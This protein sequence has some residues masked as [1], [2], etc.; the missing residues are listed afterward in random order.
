MKLAEL[1]KLKVAELRSRLKDLGLDNKGLKAELLGRLWSKLE[2]GRGEDEEEE[3]KPQHDRSITPAAQ[4]EDVQAPS[5][6]PKTGPGVTEGCK[7]D[8]TREYTDTSTQTD[9]DTRQQGSECITTLQQ[10]SECITTLQQGSECITTLQQGS[11]CITPLQQGPECVSTLQQASECVSTLQQGSECITTLQ[12]GSEC[13]STLQQGSECI[14]TLQQG[15]ECITTLQQGS[16]CITTLQQASEC[17][18]PLQQGSEC[19]TPLQQAS[20]CITPLQQASECVTPLQQASECVST[21]QQASE[22]ITPLQQA[23]ECITPLQQASECVTP[24]QQGSGCTSECVPVYQAEETD[25]EMQQGGAEDAGEDRRALSSED[26]GRGRAFYEFK[27]E[28]RYKRAKSPQPPVDREE[29]EEEDE[30]KVR[31]DAYDSHLHFEVSPD[32]AGGQPRFWARFPSLWSGCRLT[33]GVLQGRVGFEVRLERKLL[34]TQL[35]EQEDVDPYGLR[36]GWS[37]ANTSL[38]LGEDDFSFAYDGRGKKVSG[39]KEEVFGELFSEGD[40][41]GCYAS[42]STDGAVELS[43]HKNGRFM[44]EAFSLDASVLLCRPLF[45]HVLCK[46]C[47]VRFLLDPTA[48]PWYPGPP[49]FTPL[50]ALSVGQ[51]V[52]S[53]LPPTFRAQCEVVLIVGLP[54]SGKSHWARTHMKQHPEKQYKLLST[55]ELL[56]CMISGGQRDSR[57]QQASQCLTDLIKMAAQTPGNYILDQCNILFSARRYK[58]Q[59]FTGFRRRVVVVFPSA[60]EWKRRLFEHQ[61]SN[62]EQIPETA[63]LKLQ[64]SCSLPE[65]QSNLLEELQYVELPQEQA[66]TLL[67]VYRDEARRLLPPIPKQ[68]KK[69]PRLHK[70]RPHPHGPPPSHR[71]QWTGLHGWNDTRLNMQPWRQQ[72]RYWSVPYQD[73]GCYYRD[74]GY[75]GYEGY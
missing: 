6:S 52:R 46:S 24:L 65:Q 33:H 21:L 8:W 57:L 35:E 58:L 70:K 71:I 55:E 56:A 67:Q 5:S 34:T 17:I 59:L 22:C 61:T 30:D 19:I 26:M 18:T 62:G 51:K 7:P 43:F 2:A 74:V 47:S 28:I 23:P 68:E 72:P 12:Q 44:G 37:V 49:G 54:G 31:L 10:G 3:V 9:T 11:E 60:D 38:L 75:S 36:V 73:Q 39:G 66:Q 25:V 42:F 64:V 13:V 15:S 1:K 41:I 69:K 50:A 4:A 40:I 27:E 53:T 16:E 20:E 45:P 48:P 32:C 29:T 63:L 14:T